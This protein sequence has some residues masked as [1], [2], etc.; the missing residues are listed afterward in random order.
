VEFEVKTVQCKA[1]EWGR[2]DFTNVAFNQDTILGIERIG[3]PEATDED[4]DEISFSKSSVSL[5]HPDILAKFPNIVKITLGQDEEAEFSELNNQ[6]RIENC[7]NIKRLELRMKDFTGI[8]INT[9]ADCSKLESLKIAT[10]SLTDL[11]DDLFKN[12]QNLHDLELKEK[13]LKLRVSPFKGLKNLSELWLDSM[14]LNQIEENFFQSLNIK[15]LTYN[16]YSARDLKFPIESL[17]S[18][19]TIEEL[20][21]TYTDL[22]EIPENF[23][24]TLRSMKK[25]KIISLNY[26][27][28]GSVEAFV[29]LPNV[30]SINLENNQIEELPANAFK[31]CPRLTFLWLS[32]NNIRAIHPTAFDGLNNLESL[33]LS[34]NKCVNGFF[35]AEPM[36]NLKTDL[37]K[38]GLQNCFDDFQSKDL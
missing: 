22:S 5:V 3:F 9:F 21:I 20:R 19:E 13:N 25:L 4:F 35:W 17:N 36:D 37:V 15:R 26:D 34:G 30:E 6:D 12:Q 23:G 11:P 27:L 1:S 10:N 18:Q 32:S 2:C 24:P 14:S 38:E 16:A 8:S 29:D 28:I 33:G 31:G 7:Q